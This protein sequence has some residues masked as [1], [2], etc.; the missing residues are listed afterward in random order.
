[1]AGL[2]L[3]SRGIFLEGCPSFGFWEIGTSDY[4]LIGKGALMV[5]I[6]NVIYGSQEF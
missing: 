4:F 6:I 2:R 5:C 3:I 1:M